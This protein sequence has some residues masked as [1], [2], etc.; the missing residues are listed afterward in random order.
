M[1]SYSSYHVALIDS[2]IGGFSVL[3]QIESK[4]PGIGISY[5]MDSL[6]LPYGELSQDALLARLESICD[7]LLQQGEIDL[8]VIACN[9][10]STQSL[11][12][13]RKRFEHLFV[14]VV[15]AVKP[16]ANMTKTGKI[17]VL[18]TPATV[19]GKYL[20]GLISQ[21]AS[22]C[23]VEKVGSSELVHL[24]EQLFWREDE[25]AINGLSF[26][27]LQSIDTL[28][29]GCTHFP[30]IAQTIE[31]MLPKDIMLVDSGAAIANRVLSLL[32]GPGAGFSGKRIYASAALSPHRHEVL[33]QMGFDTI[34]HVDI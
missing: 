17:G 24:A 20:D 27:Q 14:G 18:A 10:A 28:V 33:S 19:A 29:L 6:Y 26:P 8:V 22:H 3:E 2:G 16:A 23:Q 7:F 31:N 5:F 9:T 32:D 15:P 25:T 1:S 12:F 13:L 30:L 11:D 4:L 34:A 21:F